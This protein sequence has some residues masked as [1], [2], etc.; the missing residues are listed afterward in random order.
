[1]S[2]KVVV[3]TYSQTLTRNENF[4]RKISYSIRVPDTVKRVV[5]ICFVE[6]SGTDLDKGS[7]IVPH[8]NF[9]TSRPYHRKNENV[10]KSPQ[11]N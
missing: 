9:H 4:K 10:I 3:K 5:N 7:S 11:Y 2:D 8:G 1:M 6:Y